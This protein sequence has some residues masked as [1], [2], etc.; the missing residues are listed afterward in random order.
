VLET[1]P[2]RFQQRLRDAVFARL[3]ISPATSPRT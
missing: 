2:D 1:F 3:A